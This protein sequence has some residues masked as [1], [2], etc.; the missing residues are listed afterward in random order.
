[1]IPPK[2]VT[3]HA[4]KALIVTIRGDIYDFAAQKSP[5]T[6]ESCSHGMRSLC[7]FLM[8]E[9][10]PKIFLLQLLSKAL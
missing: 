2:N 10:Q 3:I 6:P 1:M 7:A 4:Q 5:L 8:H 9:K